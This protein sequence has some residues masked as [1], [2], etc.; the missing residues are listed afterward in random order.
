LIHSSILRHETDELDEALLAVLTDRKPRTFHQL[1]KAIDFSHNIL[2][3]HLDQPGRSTTREE[4]EDPGNGAR[5]ASLHV[6]PR[7]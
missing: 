1:L 2:R 6:F 3:L 7:L 4:G 5:Q